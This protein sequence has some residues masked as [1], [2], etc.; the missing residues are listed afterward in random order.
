[1]AQQG[2]PAPW[3]VPPEPADT[4]CGR[5]CHG[6]LVWGNGRGVPESN[7]LAVQTM[8]R[9]KAHF[10]LRMLTISINSVSR[11]VTSAMDVTSGIASNKNTMDI[12]L[13]IIVKVHLA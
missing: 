5:W 13:C 9:G 3:L 12:L 8:V 6:R 1:M 11:A 7:L 10:E 4:G 2:A